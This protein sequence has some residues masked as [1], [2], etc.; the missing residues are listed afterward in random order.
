MPSGATISGKNARGQMSETVGQRIKRSTPA[1]KV[2]MKKESASAVDIAALS[3]L[4]CLAVVPLRNTHALL[5]RILT[6]GSPAV[7]GE[8]YAIDVQDCRPGV[9]GRTRTSRAT[10]LSCAAGLGRGPRALRIGAGLS[11]RPPSSVRACMAR[12]NRS[13]RGGAR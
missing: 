13:V 3:P 5:A 9:R 11:S 7:I 4:A 6:V 8:N 12:S 2:P 1:W 10:R